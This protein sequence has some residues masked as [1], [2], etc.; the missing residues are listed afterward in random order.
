M[1]P[2]KRREQPMK[3]LVTGGT[4]MIGEGVIPRLLG[5]GHDVRI[6]SRGAS[7]DAR[8]W[9]E[10]VE[11]FPA[12]VA[13]AAS[14]R[15]AADGCHAV[16]HIVGIAKETGDK[17]FAAINVEGTRNILAEAERAGAARFI[18]ISSLGADRGKSEYHRS[19]REAEEIVRGFKGSWV[20]LRP[21]KVYGPGDE[22]ISMLLGM[23]RTLPVVPVVAG[24]DQNFQPIW[25]RDL[26]AAVAKVVEMEE[27]AGV[28]LE[29]AGNEVTTT[30]DILDRLS[31]LTGKNPPRLGL[32]SIVV[33]VG[34][35]VA[36]LLG[37]ELPI[38]R[39][40]LTMLLEENVIDEG[41][42][43][44]LVE[45]LGITPVP[46]AEGLAELVDIQPEQVLGEG[47]GSIELKRFWANIEGSSAD[48]TELMS[49]F[50]THINDVMPIDFAAEPGAP[51]TL[52][53]GA[54][55][56][57]EIPVRGTIQMRVEESSR[58][59]VTLATLRGHPI[60]GVVRFRTADRSG[61]GIRF[62]VIVYSQAAGIADWV[63]LKTAGAPAQNA[64]WNTVVERVVELSGGT[65]PNGVETEMT[66]LD[67]EQADEAEAWIREM[68]LGR[69]REEN[70][71]STTA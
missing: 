12:D 27:L 29:I 4:G 42:P 36:D 28:T 70:R 2:A 10:H 5:A 23:V 38:D 18:F 25:Y 14:L 19:K 64:N 22:A 63:A 59:Q 1:K 71:D 60:A 66:S 30:D 7:E 9:P 48:A 8:Q 41:S 55:M 37:V 67:E 62:E 17:T 46:L 15:G 39:Q 32:P 24:G 50:K 49:S 21:G 40:K 56:T 65:A 51:T 20:I 57:A 47:V 68:I 6:L 58:H 34:T 54:T 3:L 69:K 43:N 61:H 53:Q 52:T 11:A 16:V 33:S 26:G 35:R 13:D 31:R 44:G 45:T